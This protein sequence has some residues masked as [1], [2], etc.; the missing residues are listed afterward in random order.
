[1]D[2]LE[3]LVLVMLTKTPAVS[4]EDLAKDSTRLSDLSAL[5]ALRNLQKIG[6]AEGVHRYQITDHGRRYV[7]RFLAA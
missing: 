2:D 6:Y 3:K 7:A 5:C 1:M 4:A